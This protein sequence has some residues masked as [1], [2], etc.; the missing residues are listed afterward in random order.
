MSA[1]AR[2]RQPLHEEGRFNVTFGGPAH[3]ECP[4]RAVWPPL[5]GAQKWEYNPLIVLRKMAT[6]EAFAGVEAQVHLRALMDIVSRDYHMQRPLA[7]EDHDSRSIQ[8][9]TSPS[10]TSPSSAASS[11]SS[12]LAT[13]SRMSTTPRN[14]TMPAPT[15]PTQTGEKK[16]TP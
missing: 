6:R 9:L 13:P 5:A 4:G 15:K 16:G 8:Q 1:C 11:S 12:S 7:H 2:C 14:V 3:L 10:M